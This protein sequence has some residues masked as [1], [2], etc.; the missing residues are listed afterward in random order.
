MTCCGA[1]ARYNGAY[2]TAAGNAVDNIQALLADEADY[3]ISA[4]PTCTVALEHEFIATLESLG[5]TNALPQ[6]R[7]LAEKAIDFSTLV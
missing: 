4:C 7:K 6:A 1:P 5:R 2:E 3:V